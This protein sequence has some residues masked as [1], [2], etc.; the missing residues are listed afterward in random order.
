MKFLL[1]LI[2][3]LA[4]ISASSNEVLAQK[5][6]TVTVQTNAICGMCKKTIETALYALPGIRY[7]EL[8]MDDKIVTAKF[9]SDKLSADDIRQAIANA[10]YNADELK[11]DK[12]SREKLPYCCKHDVGH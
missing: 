12:E 7:A 3:S 2:C 9:K 5:V 11:A 8:N 4:I 6:E 10:G 1:S